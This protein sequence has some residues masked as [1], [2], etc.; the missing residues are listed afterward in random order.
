MSALSHWAQ[1]GQT[2]QALPCQSGQ[3]WSMGVVGFYK[4]TS[5]RSWSVWL[6]FD[7]CKHNI[8]PKKHNILTGQMYRVKYNY[9]LVRMC[10]CGCKSLFVNLWENIMRNSR[11]QILKKGFGVVENLV[12]WFKMTTLLRLRDLRRY[13][14]KHLVQFRESSWPCFFFFLNIVDSQ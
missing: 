7:S 14:Y 8:I 3:A 12:I 5:E 10:F 11:L 2:Q 13:N 6:H 9:G 1:A 4:N